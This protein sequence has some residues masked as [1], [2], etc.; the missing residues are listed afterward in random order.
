MLYITF[1]VS[2]FLFKE[3]KQDNTQNNTMFVFICFKWQIKKWQKHI[4]KLLNL[5]TNIKMKT[6]NVISK[7][8]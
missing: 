8:E 1:H 4:T 6:K 5:K 3:R 2:S 7:Y